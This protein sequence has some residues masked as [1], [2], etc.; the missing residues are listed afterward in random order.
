ML[1]SGLH[2]DVGEYLQQQLRRALFFA[3]RSV[4]RQHPYWWV[5][6]FCRTELRK[7]T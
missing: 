3:I 6:G 5:K 7:E 1:G 2:C 4:Y